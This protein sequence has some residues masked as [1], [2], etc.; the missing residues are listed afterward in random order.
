MGNHGLEVQSGDQPPVRAAAE[1]LRGQM[2]ALSEAIRAPLGGVP[3]L[4]VE[5]KDPSS[6]VPYRQVDPTQVP[7]V[8][9]VVS[10]LVDQH[11]P[12][13]TLLRGKEVLEL[14]PNLPWDKGR[15][16]LWWLGHPF[17]PRWGG[18]GGGVSPW[19]SRP[20]GRPRPPTPYAI[21]PRCWTFCAGWPR[22]R[23]RARLLRRSPS[24]ED[25]AAR[26]ARRVRRRRAGS[27]TTDTSTP[28]R[29]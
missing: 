6:R 22:G 11:R 15:A 4:G 10:N 8:R 25:R 29:Q 17:G 20:K 18:G 7:R 3:G 16:V 27:P 5:H 23:P 28:G 13:I 9:Q 19:P 1:R 12:W 2:R 21:R 26:S 14:R 24:P